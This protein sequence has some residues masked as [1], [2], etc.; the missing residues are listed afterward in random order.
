MVNDSPLC[1]VNIPLSGYYL[2]FRSIHSVYVKL[3]LTQ[4]LFDRVLNVTG[5]ESDRQTE[6]DKV[7]NE[8]IC[9]V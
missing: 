7:F 8:I 9:T 5:N 2:T 6:V 1:T 3:S 4:G